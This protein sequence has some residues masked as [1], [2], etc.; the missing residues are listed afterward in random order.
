M[1]GC[2]DAMEGPTPVSALIHAATMVTA[3]VY[4]VARSNFIYQM[5]PQAMTVVAIIGALTAF[6]AASIALVQNDIKRVLAYSTVS[7]LGYMFLALGVGAFAAGVFHLM[8]HAFFKA[9]LFLGSGSVIHAMHHEQDMRKMGAL[10]KQD[11]HH[12]LDDVDR[13]SGDRWDALPCRLFLEGRNP[14]ES[15]LQQPGSRSAVAPGRLRRGNDR[16]LHVPPGV[17]DVLWRI[18]GRS[19][20][21]ASHSRIAEVDDRSADHPGYW[22]DR[23]G[24]YRISGVDWRQQCFRTFPRSGF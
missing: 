12:V 7:Q 18:E 8:T 4:M 17:H 3:G 5:A 20:H 23:G 2:P 16:V 24:I 9:L 15:I 1:S 11:S 13:H 19:P 22:I 21:G 10:E 14:V 6:F